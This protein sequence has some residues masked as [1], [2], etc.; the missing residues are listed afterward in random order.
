[1]HRS[2][3]FGGGERACFIIAQS[4]RVNVRRSKTQEEIP[5]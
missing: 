5:F 4:L 2:E 3:K 1:M